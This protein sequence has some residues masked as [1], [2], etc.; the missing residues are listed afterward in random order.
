MVSSKGTYGMTKQ[1]VACLAGQVRR[2]LQRPNGGVGSLPSPFG[3]NGI[4]GVPMKLRR[5]YRDLCC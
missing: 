1:T 2:V 3:T 5:V 4:G